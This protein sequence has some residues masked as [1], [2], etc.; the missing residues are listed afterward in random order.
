MA[1]LTTES[2]SSVVRGPHFAQT[3][4]AETLR[5]MTCVKRD[6][7]QVAFDPD[8]ITAA[9]RKCFGSACS[10]PQDEQDALVEKIAKRVARQVVARK[11]AS[12]GVETVQQLVIGQLWAEGLE[13][14]AKHYQD[15][16]EERRKARYNRAAS[17]A[18]AGRVKSDRSHFKTDLQYFQFMDKFSRW[19]PDQKRRETWE[20]AVFKRVLPFL[21]NRPKVKGKLTTEEMEFLGEYLYEL[22]AGPAMRV[23]QMAGPAL[24]RCNMGVYNCTYMPIADVRSFGELLYILMQGSGAG[25]SVEYDYVG[26]LPRVKK[27]TGQEK[28]TIVV[29]DSTESWCDAL[30]QVIT[31]LFEGRDFV[32]DTGRVRKKG[33]RLKTKGGKASGPEPLHELVDFV[34]GIFLARQG[35]RLSDID[36]HD[37]CCMIGNIVQVGGVRRAALISLSDLNSRS[38]R[39]AKSG[40]WWDGSKHRSMANNSAVYLE[41]PTPEVFLDEWQA[42]VQSKSGERGICN[43]QALEKSVPARRQKRSDFGFNPCVTEDTAVA[44]AD[45][46]GRVTFKELIADGKDVPVYCLDD[47]L[48]LTVRMMRR[49]RVTGVQ[50]PVLRV[51]FDNGES[52]R[53][54]PNH[55][56]RLRNGAYREARDL[57]PGDSLRVMTK[58]TP[59]AEAAGDSRGDRYVS[60]QCGQ[61]EP[62]YE[63]VMVASFAA[64]RTPGD[65]EHVHHKDENRFNNLATNLEIRQAACHLSD[66]AVGENNA[67]VIDVTNDRLIE[68]GRNLT[69][70]LGRRFS[71]KEW[72]AFAGAEG[73]PQSFSRYRAGT[74]GSVTSFSKRCA[75]LEGVDEH[76]GVDPRIIRTYRQMIDAGLDADIVDGQVVV[77][78]ECEK[79][80]CE[81]VVSR[82][83]REQGYCS[84]RCSSAVAARAT[85]TPAA[86]RAQTETFARRKQERQEQQMN[87]FITLQ[88]TLNR[89]PEKAEWVQAC[90]AAG[91][92]HEISRPSSPFVSWADLKEAVLVRNHKVVSVVAD[93]FADVCN[94]TVD[95]HHNYFIGGW[96]EGVTEGGRS[97]EGW[98]NN[99]NCG[100]IILRPYGVCNL[101]IAVARPDDTEETLTQKAIAAAY[102]GTIQATCTDFN[103]VRPEWKKNA[104]EESMLGVDI[105]GHADCPLL[106]ASNPD[107]DAMLV[108]I[109]QRV[110]EVNAELAARFGIARS[111]ADTCVKPS[112]DSAIFFDCGSGISARFADCQWRYVRASKESS[113]AKFLIDQ[114]VPYANAPERPNELY[115]FGF[116]KEAP[117]NSIKRDDQTAIEQLENWLRWKK[118]WAEHS[119]SATIYVQEWEWVAVGAWVYEHFDDITGLSFLPKDNGTYQYAPN[120]E[121]TREEFD[122]AAATFPSIAWEKL[123]LYEDDDETGAR[124]SMACF[125]GSCDA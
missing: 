31:L 88:D 78:K 1:T 41:R 67:N 7:R 56:F 6:G 3:D 65:G 37:I 48:Q 28:A 18:V 69:R 108:R 113:I 102:F 60:I 47:E 36:V 20:E 70:S 54:T 107:R 61:R 120:V 17:E 19:L 21:F 9:L 123:S 4:H 81:F 89:E 122:A 64:G 52:A 33:A 35:R 110:N 22:K 104:E 32:L 100:E 63:H 55:R 94:G 87:V 12:V 71:V 83:R 93:G 74:L 99:A 51:T 86:K 2:G 25:F 85:Q 96:D 115:V 101:S 84:S 57:R 79:C 117:K 119:V 62:H 24:E 95:E 66:H 124:T 125:G 49:P 103:Y 72:Q 45:G 30:V 11:E 53:V 73:L 39:D 114:G 106:F 91:V 68:F 121:L 82:K 16:R 111:A 109:R 77:R 14:E 43:R 90:K 105:T 40:A 38:M 15:Y 26:D 92:S 5:K 44:V 10:L 34:R 50:S 27:Q 112:G 8:R 97:R 116:L 46:R 98:I 58:Y 59:Q 118:N 76:N 13:V 29:E 23:V 42:L 80:G 75:G